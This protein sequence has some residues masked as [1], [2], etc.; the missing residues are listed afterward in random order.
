MMAYFRNWR[1]RN[2]EV[3]AL[4]KD[5][6]DCEDALSGML[7]SGSSVVEDGAYLP[8]AD[9]DNDDVSDFE[10][11]SDID[12][13][14]EPSAEETRPDLDEELAAWATRNSCKQSALNEILDTEASRT[15]ATQGCPNAAEY[16]KKSGNS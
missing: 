11:L 2:A 16:A 15:S 8:L 9:D 3:A 1:K 7:E 4:A 13:R 14:F 12:I 6:P 10:Q 5:S